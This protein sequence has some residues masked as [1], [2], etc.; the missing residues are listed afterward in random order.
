MGR[1]NRRSFLTAT[2]NT[3][4]VYDTY[5]ARPIHSDADGFTDLV[6][7]L[8]RAEPWPAGAAAARELGFSR[9]VG[10]RPWRA[11]AVRSAQSY[12]GFDT[13]V[14]HDVTQESEG[15]TASPT[16]KG[17]TAAM[18]ERSSASAQESKRIVKEVAAFRYAYVSRTQHHLR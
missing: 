18:L 10:S 8:D 9:P 1:E 11:C 3:M 5:A 14:F 16:R 6:R 2:S 4:S 7:Q 13:G 12:V 17:R 15:R